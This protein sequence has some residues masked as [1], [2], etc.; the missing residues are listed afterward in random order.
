VD[1][2]H[3]SWQQLQAE[4]GKGFERALESGLRALTNDLPDARRRF[5]LA[6]REAQGL[7]Q[8]A[9]DEA[10]LG[11]DY[12]DALV[13]LQQ[14][15]TL[16]GFKSSWAKVQEFEAALPASW[17]RVG[18]NLAVQVVQTQARK[19]L[20]EARRQEALQPLDAKL[21]GL[22]VTVGLRK[23]AENLLDPV[24]DRL[25]APLVSGVDRQSYFKVVDR[26][27]RDYEHHNALTPERRQL[28]EQIQRRLQLFP[29]AY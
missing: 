29:G 24:T 26:L 20:E 16:E 14:A 8:S 19:T 25:A 3:P 4:L 28:L 23:P 9:Q 7:S 18:T 11:L 17:P 1:P 13:A 15:G 10:R 12:V 27:Q 5:A 6:A 22:E 21:T 2:D